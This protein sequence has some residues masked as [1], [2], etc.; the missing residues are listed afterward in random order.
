VGDLFGTGK[1][2]IVTASFLN[3]QVAP[4]LLVLENQGATA[5]SR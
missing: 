3:T 1:A 5:D 4:S 2:D